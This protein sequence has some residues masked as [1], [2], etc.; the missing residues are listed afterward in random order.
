[1]FSLRAKPIT[2]EECKEWIEWDKKIGQ[3]DSDAIREK[4]IFEHE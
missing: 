2:D 3:M 1:M 4:V